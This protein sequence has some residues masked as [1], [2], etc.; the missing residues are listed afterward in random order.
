MKSIPGAVRAL[1]AATLLLAASLGHAQSTRQV[2]AVSDLHVGAGQVSGGAWNPVEDF[3]WGSEFKAFLDH[4]GRSSNNTTDL[5]LA[6]DV[7]ELWQSPLMQCSADSASPGCVIT[8]CNEKNPDLGCSEA[9]ALRRLGQVLDRHPE[10]VSALRQFV[11]AGDNRVFIV[12]GN[13]DAALLLPSARAVLAQRFASPRIVLMD[14]GYWLSEDGRI[15]AD[16]GHQADFVNQF[17]GWPRPFSTRDN[18]QYMAKPWGENMVQQFYNQYEYVFPV[19]DNLSTEAAGIRFALDRSTLLQS[20]ASVGKFLK[21]LLLQASLRQNVAL[22]GED[23]EVITEA[24]WDYGNVRA[25]PAGFFIDVLKSEPALYAQ[26]RQAQ[27]APGGLEWST[28]ELSDDQLD[29]ICKTKAMIDRDRPQDEVA[30]CPRIDAVLG[31]TW[32]GITSE[33]AAVMRAYL[34]PVLDALAGTRNHLAN[35]YIYGHT[36]RAEPPEILQLG[37]TRFGLASLEV[38]NTGAFQRIASPAQVDAISAAKS[39]PGTRVTPAALVPEDLPACY[40]YVLVAPYATL[41]ASRLMKWHAGANGK[42]AAGAGKC[43]D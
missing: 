39:T 1:L 2:V 15:Y 11:A 24:R 25:K 30:L 4:I 6:G 17:K 29:A 37:A 9:D 14:K 20:A 5:V 32:S 13:H 10:F 42:M 28:A 41:P 18:V 19:I 43:L 35:V 21:F 40:N 23:G 16:H 34:V 36:H 12:P 31:G 26:V 3:R 22:L 27:A 7:F 8:E 38:V 33:P